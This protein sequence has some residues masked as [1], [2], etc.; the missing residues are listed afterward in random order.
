MQELPLETKLL[1]YLSTIPMAQSCLTAVDDMLQTSIDWEAF[2]ARAMKN[3]VYPIVY[4][5]IK[6]HL[7]IVDEQ[8]VKRMEAAVIKNQLRALILTQE[9]IRVAGSLE[10]EGIKVMVLKGAP[11]SRSLYHDISLRASRDL[12]ILVAP[13]DIDKAD[14]LLSKLEFV[15][16]DINKDLTVKQ[17]RLI[18][19]RFHHFSYT[20]TSGI[21]LE[22]HWRLSSDYIVSFKELWSSNIEV[23]LYGSKINVLSYEQNLL[24]LILHGS[25]HG[26]KRTRWLTDIYDMIRANSLNWVY[27]R[28]RAEE[29]GILHLVEQTFILLRVIYQYQPQTDLNL[30]KKD[31]DIAQRLAKLSF[32]FMNSMEEEPEQHGHSLF[33]AYKEYILIW[34]KGIGRKIIY[35]AGHFIPTVEDFRNKRIPDRYFGLYYPLRIIKILCSIIK[36]FS[37]KNQGMWK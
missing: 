21:N 11:L 15:K 32:L 12:D 33:G 37:S 2:Y 13:N 30:S 28:N 36:Q 3:R 29:F 34:H 24:Y 20:S 16:D 19:K 31:R 8:V 22:L 7:F 4:R 14:S 27:I 18:R 25:K 6:D 1:F 5:N 10:Q 17:T 9:L 23:E 26:W 35:I